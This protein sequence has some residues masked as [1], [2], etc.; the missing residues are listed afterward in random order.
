MGNKASKQ[1]NIKPSAKGQQKSKFDPE[2][3]VVDTINPNEIERDFKWSQ[4]N[5]T[6]FEIHQTFGKIYAI[7]ARR[8]PDGV[9]VASADQAGNVTITLITGNKDKKGKIKPSCSLY[10]PKTVL[11]SAWVMALALSPSANRFVVGGL[12]N[13]VTVFDRKQ[14]TDQVAYERKAELGG[15][16]GYVSCL[17]F[18]ERGHNKAESLVLSASGD[19]SVILWDVESR[20]RL[21]TISDTSTQDIMCVDHLFIDN[22]H[23]IAIGDVDQN[24]HLLEIS[25]SIPGFKPAT[26]ATDDGDEKQA[27]NAKDAMFRKQT[28]GNFKKDVNRVSFSPN[29]E[30]LAATSD[31]ETY[32]IYYKNFSYGSYHNRPVLE[33]SFLCKRSFAKMDQELDDNVG[34]VGNTLKWVDNET[35]MVG[36]Q[37]SN[38]VYSTYIKRE[39]SDS[40]MLEAVRGGVQSIMESLDENRWMGLVDTLTNEIM[41]YFNE[42]DL[43]DY[44]YQFGK[45][46][47]RISCMAHCKWGDAEHE[48]LFVF[49]GWDKKAHGVIPQSNP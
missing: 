22:K 15:H 12:D 36:A 40:K 13:M 42:Y 14:G 17:T 30:F 3:N 45:E 34:K 47:T 2:G 27:E 11:P 37:E 1:K 28:L 26:T 7:D 10:A 29:G 32:E 41:Q 24:V 4:S 43:F 44:N 38:K 16:E 31:D 23:I 9:L 33:W 18:V 5:T 35:L 8:T 20:T 39:K 49:A 46:A 19:H 25:A 6:L 21:L 48:D